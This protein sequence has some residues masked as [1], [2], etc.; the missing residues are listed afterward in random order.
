MVV[1]LS[2]LARHLSHPLNWNGHVVLAQS[3]Q[4]GTEG[5]VVLV[6]SLLI[7]AVLEDGL[8]D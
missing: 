4:R 5:A 8:F 6:H 7:K 1:L 3:V 2:V